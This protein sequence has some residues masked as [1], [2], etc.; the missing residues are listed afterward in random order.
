M[1][2]SERTGVKTAHQGNIGTCTY[3]GPQT[4]RGL[5][6]LGTE[7]TTPALGIPFLFVYRAQLRF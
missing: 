4:S 2:S 5:T 3:F 1:Y 6:N 7:A